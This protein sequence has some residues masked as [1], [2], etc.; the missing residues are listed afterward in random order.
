[1]AMLAYATHAEMVSTIYEYAF[2]RRVAI[3]SYGKLKDIPTSLFPMLCVELEMMGDVKLVYTCTRPCEQCQLD[4]TQGGKPAASLLLDTYAYRHDNVRVL[5]G[6]IPDMQEGGI[7]KV[8]VYTMLSDPYDKTTYM[9]GEC[10]MRDGDEITVN[11][12]A[13]VASKGYEAWENGTNFEQMYAEG[14]INFKSL[15]EDEKKE[16]HAMRMDMMR[17]STRECTEVMRNVAK[18]LFAV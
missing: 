12:A 16:L 9:F 14:W 10:G 2:K 15:S 5:S 7:V 4:I 13:F 17:A 1:M 11:D 3:A 8:C 18:K 6:E